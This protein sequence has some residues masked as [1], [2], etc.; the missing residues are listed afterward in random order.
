MSIP[1]TFDEGFAR[2]REL[3]AIF[4]ANEGNTE[5]ARRLHF[6][7]VSFGKCF[8]DLKFSCSLTVVQIPG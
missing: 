2:V 5:P 6:L 3:V 4:K 7:R 8:T 1:Q